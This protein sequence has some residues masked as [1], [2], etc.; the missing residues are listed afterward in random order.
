MITS[1]P[2]TDAA[3][4]KSQPRMLPINHVF[5]PRD[6]TNSTQPRRDPIRQPGHLSVGAVS[7]YR[8]SELAR[9]TGVPA[10]TLR[11]L[12]RSAPTR[13]AAGPRV[14]SGTGVRVYR[15]IMS[16]TELDVAESWVPQACTLPTV[17]RPLRAAEFAALFAESVRS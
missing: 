12:W 17:E 8:I 14:A 5:R 10:S 16:T 6:A 7:T 9:R 2:P 11:L 13:T 3:A 1:P 4:A 15:R